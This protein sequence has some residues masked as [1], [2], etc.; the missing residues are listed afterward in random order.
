[1]D[2]TGSEALV[3]HTAAL[4]LMIQS[5]AV[6]TCHLDVGRSRMDV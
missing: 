5:G 6:C 1:M 2:T 4:Q 3:P